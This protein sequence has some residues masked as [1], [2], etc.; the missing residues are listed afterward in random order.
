MKFERHTD[1]G[2]EGGE[3]AFSEAETPEQS[4]R[5]SC[6]HESELNCRLE[7]TTGEMTATSRSPIVMPH[8][9]SQSIVRTIL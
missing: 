8:Y 7:R 2:P 1:P 4:E 5:H 3:A 9:S 6:T